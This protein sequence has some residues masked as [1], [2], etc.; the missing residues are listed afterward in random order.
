MSVH[1]RRARAI[2]AS[3]DLAPIIMLDDQVMNARFQIASTGKDAFEVSDRLLP[4]VCLLG[5][6]LMAVHDLLLCDAFS[7]FRRSTPRKECG[8]NGWKLGLRSGF[9]SSGTLCFSMT[10][11]VSFQSVPPICGARGTFQGLER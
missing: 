2:A 11:R 4:V 8:T 10:C 5:S 6:P 1:V 3:E 9:R 7:P